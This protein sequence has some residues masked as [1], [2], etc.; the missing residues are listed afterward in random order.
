M[1][2]R[3]V[4]GE[5]TPLGQQSQFLK[6]TAQRSTAA[7]DSEGSVT[8]SYQVQWVLKDRVCG[9]GPE[10]PKQE[11]TQRSVEEG[12]R[13]HQLLDLCAPAIEA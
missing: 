3:K 9:L 12:R 2:V 10:E 1:R 4:L 5:K 7:L 8:P 6:I 11:G 13:W